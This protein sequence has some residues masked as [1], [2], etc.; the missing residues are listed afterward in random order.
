MTMKK[1]RLL[2]ALWLSVILLAGCSEINT[3]VTK[4][5]V[6]PAVTATSPNNQ[7]AAKETA[8]PDSPAAHV[9]VDANFEKIQGHIK[10]IDYADGNEIFIVADNLY[11]Y[12][13]DTGRVTAEISQGAFDQQRFQAIKNG[14]VAVEAKISPG[15][16]N[17]GLLT[18][19]GGIAYNAIF[20]DRELNKESEFHFNTLLNGN[21][22]ILSLE[23]I[24]FSADGTQAAYATSDGLYL[25]DF[26]KNQKT[27]VVD[28]KNDDYETR[29]GVVEIEQIGFTNEDK[30]LAF[31]AQ[32]FD[33][34]AV[35]GKPS[36]D[37][38]GT[39]NL[40]GSGLSNRTFDNYTCKELTAY[41]KLLL[42]A[43]DFT[44]PSGRILV[45]EIPG[46][47]TKLYTL[48]EKRESG[49]I[50]GSD[51]GR[52]FATSLSDKTGWKIRVYNTNTGKLEAEQ[53][54]S[55]DGEALYMANDPIVKI[56]DDTRTYIVLVGAKQAGI[57]TKVVV[58][59][60]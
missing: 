60:F 31:K 7:G 17:G 59:Q 28:L 33:I 23:A 53:R 18:T 26:K 39:V 16:S 3:G 27:T 49:F 1:K 19:D 35:I 6:D 58:G 10:N 36:F 29:S 5:S 38:C 48:I 9:A 40:D 8:D 44:M 25:Y 43:E 22:T 55:S 57:E 4:P 11:L 15:N 24:A 47:K 12:N 52:Y 21:E 30:T 13:L 42:L 54:I 56:M 14:Y 37:T 32:S 45:M 50:S 2:V 34:P 41:N 20:Y 51:T 46:G